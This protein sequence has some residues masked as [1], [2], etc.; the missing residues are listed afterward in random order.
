MMRCNRPLAALL[1]ALISATPL[2]AGPTDFGPGT[3][4]GRVDGLPPLPAST[5]RAYRTFIRGGSYFGAFAVNYE[6]EKVFWIRNFH[7]AGHVRAAALEG[8]RQLSE[9]ADGCVIYAVAMPE[10]LPVGQSTASGLSRAASDAMK[11]V[12]LENRKPGTFAAFAISGASHYGYA[13][14]YE[15]AADA[16]DTALAYCTKGV[17]RDMADFGIEARK[18]VRPR[19]WDKC[20]VVDV[21]FTPAD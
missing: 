19:G 21:S 9:G 14:A 15:K 12:Y 2:A 16:R 18:F 8:C 5:R 11:T 1:I 13:N 7:D 17:A 4:I 6:T 10:S 20:E 3:Q